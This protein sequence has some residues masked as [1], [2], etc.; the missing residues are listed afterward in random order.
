MLDLFPN[1]IQR[2]VK[3]LLYKYVQ[4]HFSSKLENQQQGG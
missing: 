3:T 2:H 4:I 1:Q